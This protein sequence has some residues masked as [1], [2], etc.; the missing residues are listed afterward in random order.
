MKGRNNAMGKYEMT[1][2]A[3]RKDE[4]QRQKDEIKN[5]KKKHHVI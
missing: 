3:T 1:D 4:Y 5:I 2:S